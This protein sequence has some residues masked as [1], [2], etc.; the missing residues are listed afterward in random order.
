LEH[1]IKRR[2]SVSVGYVHFLPCTIDNSL[3]LNW[4]YR[5]A[6]F[7]YLKKFYNSMDY[8][9]TV[10]PSLIKKIREYNITK[11]KICCIPNFVSEKNFFPK[12]QE[13]KDLIRERYGIPKDKF[14]VFGAGQLQTRKG[15]YDFVET[16]KKTPDAHFIWAGGFSFGKMTDGYNEIRRIAANPPAN[17]T[18]PGI[19]KRSEMNDWFNIA[20]IFFLPSFDELFPMVILEA[21]CCK[22]PI[23]LRDIEIY[24]DILDGCYLS[25]KNT[26]E[27]SAN[28]KT[29]MSDEG[30]RDC[31]RDK[32]WEFHNKYTEES[33]IRQWDAFYSAAYKKEKNPQRAI[34]DKINANQTT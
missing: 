4:L 11:P 31:W 7:W 29:L 32:S 14:V 34:S 1:L 2:K 19:I 10:N 27:F 24:R 6:F 20:D 16:A 22:T 9:V 28:I 21:L 15:I 8:L 5:R 12:T 23:L 30:A 18:F 13:E 33:I 25:G 3:K 17:V 26:D